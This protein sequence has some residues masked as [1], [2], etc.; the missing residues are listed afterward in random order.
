M[1]ALHD[2]VVISE[3]LNLFD[4][5]TSITHG[6]VF[7]LTDHRRIQFRSQGANSG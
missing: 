7:L 4:L 2:D 6:S 5:F 1:L 3:R